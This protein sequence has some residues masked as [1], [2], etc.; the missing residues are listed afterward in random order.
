[1][2]ASITFGIMIAMILAFSGIAFASVV[3][4]VCVVKDMK[5][6]QD[7]ELLDDSIEKCDEVDE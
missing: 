2:L 3:I 5:F 7:R 4:T 6:W 1:M